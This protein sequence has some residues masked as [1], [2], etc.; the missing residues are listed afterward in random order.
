LKE[1]GEQ[2]AITPT[3]SAISQV[4]FFITDWHPVR[5]GHFAA[6]IAAERSSCDLNHGPQPSFHI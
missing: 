4:A 3:R 1:P 2:R 5:L 6:S